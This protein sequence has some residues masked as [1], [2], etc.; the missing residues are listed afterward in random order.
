MIYLAL[1]IVCSMLVSVLMRASEKHIR[2]NVGMLAMNYVMCTLMALLFTRG[3]RLFPFDTSGSTFAIILG[4]IN[5]MLYLGAFLLLQWNI[6]ISGV[7]LPS[8]FMKI[9][10]IVPI[11]LSITVFGDTPDRLQIIGI[12]ISIGAILLIQ[13][14]KGTAKAKSGIGLV[15]VMLCGGFANA[16][17]KVYEHYGNAELNDHFLL[18]TFICAMI[19]CIA[20]CIAKRQKLNLA[21]VI[22]GMMIGIPNYLSSRFLLLALSDGISPLIVYP[23]SS[24]GSIVLITLAGVVFFRE[25]LSKRQIIALLLILVA[26]VLLNLQVG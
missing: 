14:E 3:I 23:S 5:G 15:M 26:L 18:Y 2:S 11:I 4:V 24:V 16:M 12:V 19:L 13:L 22:F 10:V 21:D 9:G 8:T 7:V 17:S 25:K 1:S 20:I 6:R